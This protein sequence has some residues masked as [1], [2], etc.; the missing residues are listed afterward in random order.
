MPEKTG[1]SCSSSASKC[2][3]SSELGRDVKMEDVEM[4]P[5][6][7]IAPPLLPP[8]S[9]ERL[10]G[11]VSGLVDR[12]VLTLLGRWFPRFISYSCPGSYVSEQVSQEY[13]M[14]FERHPNGVSE[15][16]LSCGRKRSLV[17]LNKR[18]HSFY[19]V[20]PFVIFLRK[21][22]WVKETTL[23]TNIE[24]NTSKFRHLYLPITNELIV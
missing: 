16:L 18:K 22:I 4:L 20:K 9:H 24:V 15:I 14:N 12:R 6:G 10:T 19:M 11:E 1:A 23:E 7:L 13:Y 3:D 8:D 21:W 2:D 17:L 5:R